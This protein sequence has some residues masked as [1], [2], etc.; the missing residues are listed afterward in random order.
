MRCFKSWH[1]FTLFHAWASVTSYKEIL[2]DVTGMKMSLSE[3]P[4]QCSNKY[5]QTAFSSAETNITDSEIAKMLNKGIIEN[6]TH[7]SNEIISNIFTRTK[8]DGTHRIILNLK[9]FNKNVAYYHFKMDSL[10]S[11][12]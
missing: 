4:S 2:S 11:C 12:K 5:A 6:V 9:D 1:N 7:E 10:T 3:A 8:K